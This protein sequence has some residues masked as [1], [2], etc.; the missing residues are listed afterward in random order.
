MN[1]IERVA[2]ELPGGQAQLARELEVSPQ[3]V[4]QLATGRRPVPPRQAIAIEEKYGVSRHELRPD[5]FGPAPELDPD[6][7]RIVP[8]TEMP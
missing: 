4:S 7:G 1:A 3:F 6:A 2:K 8:M 5:V